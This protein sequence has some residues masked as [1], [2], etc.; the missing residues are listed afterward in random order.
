MI[1]FKSLTKAFMSLVLVVSFLV[2]STAAFAEIVGRL[3]VHWSPSTIVQ[4]TLKYLLMKLI[5][6]QMEN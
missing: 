5:K 4:N 3:S 6:E 1:K 2:S